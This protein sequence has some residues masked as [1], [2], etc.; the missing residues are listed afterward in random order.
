M[1]F[2]LA[3][4]L[5]HLHS[6]TSRPQRAFGRRTARRG[7]VLAAVVLSLSNV[8]TA[9]AEARPGVVIGPRPIT[10]TSPYPAGCGIDLSQT[11][12]GDGVAHAEAEPTLAV[13]PQNERR[14]VTAWM[15]DLYQGYVSASSDNGGLTWHTSLVPGNSPCSGSDYEL[16]ADPWLSIGPD[17]SVYLAGISLDLSESTP[18]LPFRSKIQVNRSSDGGR[19]WSDPS[20]IIAGAGRL[21]D[22]PSITADPRRAG[23]AYVVWTEFVTPLGP[24]ADGIYFARTTDGARTWSEPARI[25]FPMAPGA[26]PH[27]A[28]VLAL[29]DESLLTLTTMRAPNGSGLPHQI[30]ANRSFDGGATW[31]AATLVAEFPATDRR[32]S[33][34]WDDPQTGEPID[35]PEWAISAAAA[36]DGTAYVTWRHAVALG[37][38]EIRFSKSTDG[39]STWTTPGTIVGTGAQRFLPVVAVTHDGTVGVTY[40]DDRRDIPQDT[41]Y[42]ADLWF[43]HSHDGGATWKESHVG[44]PFDL[45]QTLLRRIP[46]RGRFVGDY[47]GLVPVAGGFVA[48]FALGQPQAGAGGS[49]IFWARLVTGPRRSPQCRSSVSDP[50]TMHGRFPLDPVLLD[51]GIARKGR[52]ALHRQCADR[53]RSRPKRL[54]DTR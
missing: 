49:D 24:P 15:Q 6:M 7:L 35:A 13:S 30:L 53:E 22:K 14:L 2:E 52:V 9:G 46:V 23:R 19:T 10:S 1:A 4:R 51:R 16:A 43:A 28:L 27:G 21:H 11:G 18:R 41:A 42:S 3:S 29:G 47:H 34:P 45:R 8:L 17:E 38:A 25:D 48:S 12:Y 39:G 36:P 26:T 5:R 37:G 20:V 31:T 40:Y 50:P 44:G 54:R 33:T 32:H